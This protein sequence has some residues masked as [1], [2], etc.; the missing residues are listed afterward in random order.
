MPKST[1]CKRTPLCIVFLFAF[2][3]ASCSNPATTTPDPVTP[4]KI[5]SVHLELGYPLDKDTTDDYNMWLR[6]ISNS[7]CQT[8]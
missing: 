6:T 3:F 1:M 4:P 2:L 5:Q 8:G 7:M